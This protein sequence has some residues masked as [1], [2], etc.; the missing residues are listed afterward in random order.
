M[1]EFIHDWRLNILGER[2][3]DFVFLTN[4]GTGMTRQAFWCIIKRYVA[5]VGIKAKISPRTLWH[6]FATHLLNHGADLRVV[7]LLLGQGDLSTTQIYTHIAKERLKDIHEQ[8][9]PR[10]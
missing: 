1:S 2:K 10:G 3:T 7:Q 4:R 9:H 5:K 8:F 6:A